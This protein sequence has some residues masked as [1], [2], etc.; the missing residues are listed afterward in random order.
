MHPMSRNR[1]APLRRRPALRLLR[2]LGGAPGLSL[3][4]QLEELLNEV[5]GLEPRLP[6]SKCRNCKR[7]LRL[8]KGHWFHVEMYG[9][10]YQLNDFDSCNRPWPEKCKDCGASIDYKIQTRMYYEQPLCL[11]CIEKYHGGDNARIGLLPKGLRKQL[12]E[13]LHPHLKY[14]TSCSVV[15]T[16]T[17]LFFEDIR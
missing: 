9:G 7:D 15:I 4:I 17:G 16:K 1:Q 5:R 12:N 14:G 11:S 10:V 6:H 8:F 2:R 3:S 13:G